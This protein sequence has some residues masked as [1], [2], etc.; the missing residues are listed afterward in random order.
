MSS[1]I[2]F[3]L[4]GIGTGSLYALLGS[5]LVMS[6]KGTGVINFGQCAMAMYATFQY[7]Q[8]RTDGSIRLPWVGIPAK[9]QIA[10]GPTGAVPAIAA[11]VLTGLLL[12]AMAH[13]LVF[14]PI[15]KASPLAK[16]VASVGVLL[17]LNSIAILNFGTQTQLLSSFLPSGLIR[18]FL[19]LGS[20][21]SVQTLW[22]AGVS[23]ALVAAIWA[24][25]RFA[26]F[27]VAVRASASNEMGATV[28]GYSPT[29]L[30]LLSWLLSGVAGALAGIL[31]G[32]V[33]GN[34]DAATYTSL[35][36]PALGAALLGGL[37]SIPLTWLG[38]IFLGAAASF[39]VWLSSHGALPAW[40]VNGASAAIPM[41]AIGA[42]LIVR[43]DRLPIRGS[44]G[45][46]LLPRSPYPVRVGLWTV[47]C[48]AAA[49]LLGAALSG[50]WELALTTSIISVILILS[51]VILTGYSGQVSLAQ[52]TFSGIGALVMVRLLSNGHGSSIGA[53]ALHGPGLP[54]IVALPAALIAAALIGIVVGLPAVRVRG[55]QLAVVTLA[56]GLTIQDLVFTNQSVSGLNG[57]TSVVV[58]SP[59]LFGLN[60][61][62]QGSHGQPDR[63]MF[64]LFAVVVAAAAA[65][66]VANTR[67]SGTGRRLLAVR[68]NERAAAAAGIN[69]FRTKLMVFAVSAALAALAGCMFAFQQQSISSADWDAF[70]GLSF[71]AYGYMAGLTSVAGGVI[72]GVIAPAALFFYAL[73]T[74]IHNVAQ[75]VELIGGI[76]LIINMISVPEGIAPAF[77]E[78]IAALRARLM[79]SAAKPAA[80]PAVEVPAVDHVTKPVG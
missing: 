56:A 76:G 64:T 69:V 61:S 28:I 55:V 35:L 72:G 25:Y 52:V 71:L 24:F 5:S 48:S 19:G 10:S 66:W 1:A 4:L 50:A 59:T 79:R 21:F 29:R 63:W 74:G 13:Y 12:G 37:R 11:A 60:L 17:Y 57:A 58:P 36:V 44:V 20:P 67:R 47:V 3:L 33:A 15:R 73:S 8:M 45:A 78:R 2:Y 70:T 6:F 42:V 31:A 32:P 34:L 49:L 77:Q 54:M 40:A 18:N 14:R 38:G 23:A 22:I 62:V 80:L 68:A 51:Y 7:S 41:L 43:G 39:V 53:A 27:G 65:L 75:Y 46:N 9:I 26:R 16:V 30:A